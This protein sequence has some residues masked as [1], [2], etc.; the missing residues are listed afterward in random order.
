M[1]L[2]NYAAGKTT[3]ERLARSARTAS[4]AVDGTSESV[5]SFSEI[6]S[7]VDPEE[8]LARKKSRAKKGCLSNFGNM[9]CNK[10]V[11]TQEEMLQ[12]FL[13]D[14]TLSS[15]TSNAPDN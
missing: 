3:N 13:A 9:C 6:S 11:P 5:A 7:S 1:H 4:A 10:H 15:A 12:S 8:L 2:K 14:N